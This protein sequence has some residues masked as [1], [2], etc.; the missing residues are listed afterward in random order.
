MVQLEHKTYDLL[1]RRAKRSEYLEEQIQLS[2]VEADRLKAETHRLEREAERLTRENEILREHYAL[3]RQRQFGT[4]S[5]RT[6]SGQERL[7]NEVEECAAPKEP[8][9]ETVV[10]THTRRKTKGKQE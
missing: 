2:Q 10:S 8:A 7:F 1:Q 5:E 4:S 9:S 3:S 6:P